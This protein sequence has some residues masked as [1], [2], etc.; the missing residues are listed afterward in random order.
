ML[1][2]HYPEF[3]GPVCDVLKRC[4]DDAIEDH[5]NIWAY[6]TKKAPK[7][8]RRIHRIYGAGLISCDEDTPYDGPPMLVKSIAAARQFQLYVV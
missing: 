4:S 5:Y 2:Y 3:R 8:L 6:L 7:S 1:A